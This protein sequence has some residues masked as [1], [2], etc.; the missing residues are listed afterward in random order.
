MMKL[1]LGSNKANSSLNDS[2]MKLAVYAGSKEPSIDLSRKVIW[3][4]IKGDSKYTPKYQK[5]VVLVISL[6]M[7]ALLSIIGVAAMQATGLE[8]KMAGNMRDRNIAFQAAEAGMR[9]AEN[10]ILGRG[11]APRVP[12]ING[13]T[14]FFANCNLDNANNTADDGLCDRSGSVMSSNTTTSVVWDAFTTPSGT[15]YPALT[16]DMT[17]PPSVQYGRYTGA[18]PLANLSAQPRYIIESLRK[19][20]CLNNGQCYR[21]TVRAQ[22]L[23]SNTVV[24]LQSVYKPK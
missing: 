1:S 19:I 18:R 21:I 5:G 9:D 14:N 7:L 11:T 13:F 4:R 6:I 17:A 8:E 3:S 23:N 2:I 20:D 15:N 12:K 24:W 22:G 10:D 16:L